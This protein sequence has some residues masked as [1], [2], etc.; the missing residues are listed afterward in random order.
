M[1]P[2]WSLSDR[3]T[4]IEDPALPT[5]L[6]YGHADVIRGLEGQWR[7]GLDPWTLKFEGERWY[8]RGEPGLTPAEKCYAWNTFDVLAFRTGNPENP[9]NAIPPRAVAA[10]QIRYTVDVH[11]NNLVPALRKAPGRARLSGT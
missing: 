10:C 5:V 1:L 7:E 2:R 11:P 3:T 4:Q 9:V 8:G 6:C